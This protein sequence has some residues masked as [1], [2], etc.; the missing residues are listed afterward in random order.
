MVAYFKAQR[1]GVD[2]M[3]VYELDELIHVLATV[4]RSG[5]PKLLKLSPQQHVEYRYLG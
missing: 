2:L 3:G 5:S 4:H 1:E